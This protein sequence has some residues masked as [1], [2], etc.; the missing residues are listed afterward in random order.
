MGFAAGLLTLA[1]VGVIAFM[2]RQ[3]LSAALTA[4]GCKYPEHVAYLHGRI[5]LT[6]IACVFALL[7]VYENVKAG[8][9]QSWVLYGAVMA[10]GLLALRIP[11]GLA[12]AA[13]LAAMLVLVHWQIHV[14]AN[15]AHDSGADRDDAVEIGARALLAGHNPWDETSI[16]DLP[17]TTGPSSLIVALPFVAATG[18]INSLSFVGWALLF[19]FCVAGDIRYRNNSLPTLLLLL[20]LPASTFFHTMFWSLDEL[21]WAAI[22][23]PLLWIALNRQMFAT[24]GTVAA[25]MVLSRL[26]YAFG[27]LAVGL[28]WLL[29]ERRKPTSIVRLAAGGFGTT[30]FAVVTLWMIGGQSFWARNFVRNV[31]SEP[32]HSTANSVSA[33]ITSMIHGR[34]SQQ[35]GPALLVLALTFALSLGLRHQR[36]PFLHMAVAMLLAHTITFSPGAPNDYLMAFLIP[37]MYG[38]AFS[39]STGR[40]T[41]GTSARHGAKGLSHALATRITSRRGRLQVTAIFCVVAIALVAPYLAKAPKHRVLKAK[42]SATLSP[43][44]S[45][46]E[47]VVVTQELI[48]PGK[49]ISEVRVQVGTYARSN[50]GNL[51]LTVATKVGGAWQTVGTA[52]TAK[53]ILVDNAFHT[54]VFNPALRTKSKQS[55]SLT[56]SADGNANSAITWWGNPEWSGRKHRLLVNGKDR[57]GIAQFT[58]RYTPASGG[59]RQWLSRLWASITPFA[60]AFWNVLFVGSCLVALFGA[61]HATLWPWRDERR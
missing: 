18:N 49:Q 60:S 58:I 22:I 8:P 12:Y 57:P 44:A 46:H 38:E 1:L 56:L 33:A 54:F 7:G 9:P 36:Q 11:R 43:V 17:I 10:L 20:L 13:L 24:A 45:I 30:A 26:S 3:R 35:W 16:L 32:L 55:L 21:Y 53:A 19:V 48:A 34:G 52:T 37:A 47:G 40:T 25:L 14:A 15:G 6:P 51:S 2:Q 27:V 28:W 50:E 61:M 23:S 5:E 4:T 59:V 42:S 41:D 29:Q 39:Q 31:P